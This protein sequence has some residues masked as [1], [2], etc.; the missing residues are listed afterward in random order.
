MLTY[1]QGCE[2]VQYGNIFGI[3][4]SFKAL[5]QMYG[6]SLF[7]L[8]ER[9]H[10]YDLV[11]KIGTL[12]SLES[13]RALCVAR[14]TSAQILHK[15]GEML[16]EIN[17]DVYVTRVE[18]AERTGNGTFTKVSGNPDKNVSA[19]ITCR[20]VFYINVLRMHYHIGHITSIEARDDG[21]MVFE[22][23]KIITSSTPSE[24]KSAPIDNI[25]GDMRL[26]LEARN[27]IRRL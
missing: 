19:L 15:L 25:V 7:E 4:I 6:K 18:I 24:I 8:N 21:Q 9:I 17:T 3:G 11:W 16:P 12:Q 14:G 10:N 27:A 22:C 23:P 13:R 5:K 20:I 1:L 2:T 26:L